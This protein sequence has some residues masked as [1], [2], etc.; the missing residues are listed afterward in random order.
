MMKYLARY[1][2]LD[3]F[4]GYTFQ[5]YRAIIVS[6]TGAEYTL[7][8]THKHAHVQVLKSKINAVLCLQ[9]YQM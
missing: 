5:R 4:T 9:Q 6:H 3:Y 1:N 8:L 7:F 2:S